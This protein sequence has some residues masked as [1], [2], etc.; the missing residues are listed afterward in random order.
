MQSQFQDP[1]NAIR[2]RN[3]RQTRNRILRRLRSAIIATALLMATG[4]AIAAGADTAMLSLETAIDNALDANLDMISARNAV[5]SAAAGVRSA[6]TSP[7]PIFSFG[8]TSL[9]PGRQMIPGVSRAGDDVFRIDQPIEL[10]GKRRARV[11]AARDELAAAAS[12]VV[13][14]RRQIRAA[15]TD[16]WF[17]LLAAEQRLALYDGIAQSYRQSQTLAERRL[18]AGAISTGDLARQRVEMLRAESDQSRAG[19]DRREA[20]LALALLIGRE[21]EAPVL[22]SIGDGASMQNAMARSDPEDVAESRPDVRAA[23]E[24]LSASRNAL[25]GARALRHPDISIGAQYEHD[26]N[27][28]GNSVGVGFS[29]PLQIGNRYGGVIDSAGVDVA[30]AEAIAAKARTFAIAEIKTARRAADDASARRARFDEDLLPSARKAAATAEFAYG[31]GAL[32][33]VDLLDARR[34]LQ[35]VE[36]AA[37]DARTDEAK[38]RARRIAAETPEQ[39]Q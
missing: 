38:A 27:A 8:A 4:P 10:G 18:Q 21:V 32:A 36:L 16:A 2:T 28:A 23:D 25:Q 7:N 15:V 19:S 20:Q 33:L 39:P 26:N 9:T 22:Q 37:I 5:R 3:H 31:R 1:Q 34:T 29:I 30:Q 13:D 17:N 12:D 6:N 35:S 11:A 24:R 14:T